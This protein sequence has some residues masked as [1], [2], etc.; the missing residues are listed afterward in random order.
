MNNVI[1]LEVQKSY[2]FKDPHGRQVVLRQDG[3]AWCGLVKLVDAGGEEFIVVHGLKGDD[4]IY[5]QVRKVFSEIGVPENRDVTVIA[6]S[7]RLINHLLKPVT[8]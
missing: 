1:N 7:P 4:G 3:D 8:T 2:V 6:G 5:E